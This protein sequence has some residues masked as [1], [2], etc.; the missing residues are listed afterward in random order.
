MADRVA[1]TQHPAP[2]PSGAGE[3]GVGEGGAER[4]RPDRPPVRSPN[5]PP[6]LVKQPPPV[7]VRLSQ[8]LW[9]LSFA[10]GAAAV[11]YFFIIRK[12]Q[13][14]LIADAIRAVDD[15][16]SD[17]TYTT[18]ADIVFWSVFTILVT[19]L[20][21]Q[22]TLLVSFMSRRIGIRWWQLVTFI[23]QLLLFAV[24]LELVA[25]GDDGLVLR[26]LLAA[27]CGLVLLALLL[28]TL[29]SAIAWTARQHDVRRGPVGSGGPDL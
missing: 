18:A 28:S 29:P 19:V 16:R 13:L 12:T 27:Q 17:Q 25:T 20:F 11:V 10:T 15:G 1:D 5:A 22:I 23:A 3:A 2:P 6:V 14:P 8:L 26:Q 9:V 24:S 4:P 21:V 7:S